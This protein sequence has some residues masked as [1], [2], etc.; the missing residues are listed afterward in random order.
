M[1][2][3]LVLVSFHHKNTEKVA[4]AMARVLDA[5][6]VSPEQVR[7]EELRDYDLIGWGSGI[8]GDTNHRD[9]LELADA[10][11]QVSTGRAFIFSTFGAP[12]DLLQDEGR[13]EYASKCHTPLREKLQSK[14]YHIVGEF[15]C[16]G[17]NTNGFLKFFG[18]LNKGRPHVEDLKQAEQFVESL[19]HDASRSRKSL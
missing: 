18:G 17:L 14:G 9:L 11:P 10:M 7:P 5:P 13:Q 4:Q 3:L 2:T 16:P 19:R 12:A 8:Y 15:S 1:K 6:V